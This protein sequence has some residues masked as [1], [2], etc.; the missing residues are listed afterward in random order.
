VGEVRG[1]AG[2]GRGVVAE[3]VRQSAAGDRTHDEIGDRR[4]SGPASVSTG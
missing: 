2:G 4:A 1:E 3:P